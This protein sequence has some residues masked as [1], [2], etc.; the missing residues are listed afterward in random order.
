VPGN[1][2]NCSDPRGPDYDF[3]QGSML[4]RAGGREVCSPRGKRAASSW[5]L[6][7]SNGKV[8][9]KLRWARRSLGGMQWGSATDGKRIYAA[10]SN[11]YGLLNGVGGDAGTWAALDRPPA[12][13]PLADRGHARRHTN[14]Q[15]PVS[16]RQWRGVCGYDR[17]GRTMY[18][19]DAASGKT[20]WTFA[21]GGSV[22]AGAAIRERHRVLGLRLTESQASACR[23]IT[24]STRSARP[25]AA[26]TEVSA[27]A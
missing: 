17:P 15:G 8:V 1:E 19:L 6:D 4:Y 2:G 9:W 5:A 11:N 27:R 23:A 18:A 24:S 26:T 13:I 21:S 12:P 16:V 10:V 25:A 3:G 7:P 20:L 14:N 22:V